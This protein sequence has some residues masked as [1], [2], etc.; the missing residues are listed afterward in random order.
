MEKT[1]RLAG[2]LSAEDA[3]R[4]KAGKKLFAE[5]CEV[6]HTQAMGAAPHH[7]VMFGR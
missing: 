5:R 7:K 2:T 3:K 1:G 6:C 4:L